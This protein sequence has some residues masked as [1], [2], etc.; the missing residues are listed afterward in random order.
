MVERV[1]KIATQRT[2]Q[3]TGNFKLDVH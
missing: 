1:A 2:E 3:K